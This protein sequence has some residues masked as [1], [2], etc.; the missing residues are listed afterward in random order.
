MAVPGN[1]RTALVTGASRGIGRAIALGL[2]RNGFDVVVNDIVRQEAEL[3]AVA[4][5]IGGLGRRGIA[6]RSARWW[7]RPWRRRAG[8]TPWSTTPAS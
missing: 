7:M 8:S 3:A 1:G 2:A 6:R 5:E 4:E